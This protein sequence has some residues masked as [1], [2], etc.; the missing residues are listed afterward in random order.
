MT[1]RK[2]MKRSTKIEI[3]ALVGGVPKSRE[4]AQQWKVALQRTPNARLIHL[5]SPTAFKRRNEVL[6]RIRLPEQNKHVGRCFVLLGCLERRYRSSQPPSTRVLEELE[7]KMGG[8]PVDVNETHHFRKALTALQKERRSEEL[9]PRRIPLE[10]MDELLYAKML[11]GSFAVRGSVGLQSDRLQQL[12]GVLPRNRHVAE[13][14][15]KIIA[16]AIRKKT[17]QDRVASRLTVIEQKR[18]ERSLRRQQGELESH[19][20]LQILADAGTR[21]IGDD[22]ENAI[23]QDSDHPTAAV[24]EEAERTVS[25]VSRLQT[26]LG[27]FF[28]GQ[29]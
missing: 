26:M 20:D 23:C 16:A 6:R 21:G 17:R 19:I 9:R 10:N 24:E 28:G 3:E 7:E 1:Q 25:F 5:A 15:K 27:V 18:R 14:W 22:R 8:Y 4:V 11:L 13:S 2:H 12:I 29:R